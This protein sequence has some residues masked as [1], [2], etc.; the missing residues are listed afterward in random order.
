MPRWQ[1][2]SRASQRRVPARVV[3][4]GSRAT[5]G[6]R[7]ATSARGGCAGMRSGP[8]RD[9]LSGRRHRKSSSVNAAEDILGVGSVGH[10]AEA[11]LG[12]AS[13]MARP[14]ASLGGCRCTG[15]SH[16]PLRRPHTEPHAAGFPESIPSRRLPVRPESTTLATDRRPTGQLLYRTVS[17]SRPRP[18]PHR[19]TAKK[20]VRTLCLRPTRRRRLSTPF[21]ATPFFRLP[22]DHRYLDEHGATSGGFVLWLSRLVERS[23][24]DCRRSNDTRCER[25]I[26]DLG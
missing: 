26:G 16:F 8:R 19:P 7:V 25:A 21:L 4:Y 3:R 15:R 11:S 14:S 6:C 9:R 24:G 1:R 17:G 10:T 2:R 5:E 22:Y 20:G 12:G 23:A 13:A 18:I